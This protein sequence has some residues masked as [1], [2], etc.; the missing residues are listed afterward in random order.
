[1]ARI[2]AVPA[3]LSLLFP[4]R[5]RPGLDSG[6]MPSLATLATNPAQRALSIDIACQLAACL[7]MA[8]LMASIKKYFST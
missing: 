3:T 5:A 2:Y 4:Q 1:M 7:T 8:S 6:A